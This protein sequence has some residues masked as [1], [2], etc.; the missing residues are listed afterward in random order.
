MV[1]A[2]CYRGQWHGTRKEGLGAY[3]Y[4]SGAR[5]E[6]E[7]RD[8]VKDGRG[9]YYFPAGGVYEGE[10]IG[11]TATGLGVRT[12]SSGQVKAGR[13]RAGKLEEPLE[14][15]QCAVAA[16]GAGDAALASRR[17][18]VGGGTLQDAAARVCAQPALWAALVGLFIA[19]VGCGLPQSVDALTGALAPANR[20]LLLMAAGATM[21]WGGD[22]SEGDTGGSGSATGGARGGPADDAHGV[23]AAR[24][25]V[26]LFVA[27]TLLLAT[28]WDGLV[29]V[30]SGGGATSGAAAAAVPEALPLAVVAIGLMS[31]AHPGT[32]RAAATFRLDE[33]ACSAVLTATNV[34]CVPAMA[35]AA[36]AAAAALGT[37]GLPTGAGAAALGCAFMA[38]AAAAAAVAAAVAALHRSKQEAA[39]AAARP[40]TGAGKVR[41]VYTGIPEGAQQQSSEQSSSGQSSEPPPDGP[42]PSKPPSSYRGGGGRGGGGSGRGSALS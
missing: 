20:H 36:L 30:L 12:M 28:G 21:A 17:V 37:T 23:A 16:E 27:G 13:W 22:G 35:A 18:E 32:Q 34:L 24:A 19:T 4:P 29:Q 39:Q 42:G 11:G 38:A 7:W 14:L 1:P 26:P 10:W 15:W 6:G 25:A 2:R 8:N 5:Y 3:T 41:M 33:R 9:V 31:P 40:F